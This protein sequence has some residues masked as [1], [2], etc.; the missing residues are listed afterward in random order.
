MEAENNRYKTAYY[1]Q[2]DDT[3]STIAEKTP[4][5]DS[6]S[7]ITDLTDNQ[8]VTIEKLNQQ[9][10]EIRNLKD[11]LIKLQARFSTEEPGKPSEN[12]KSTSTTGKT[13]GLTGG[14]L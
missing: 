12:P 9:E 5:K 1:R 11:S 8:S 13:S 4:T 14:Q 7:T 10:E 3:I 6:R 2:D